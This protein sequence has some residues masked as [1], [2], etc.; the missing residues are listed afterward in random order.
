M[1]K[2]TGEKRFAR[3]CALAEREAD[4]RGCRACLGGLNR[5]IEVEHVIRPERESQE[6]CIILT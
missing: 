4:G 3:R 2:E 1:L 5:Q 6:V